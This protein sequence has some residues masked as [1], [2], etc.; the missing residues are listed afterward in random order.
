VKHDAFFNNVKPNLDSSDDQESSRV[1]L[2]KAKFYFAGGCARLMFLFKTADVIE[3]LT[4]S[5]AAVRDIM[6]YIKGSLG[7]I[8]NAVINRL[9]SN[10]HMPG[11]ISLKARKICIVSEWAASE[12]C[13]PD[14]VKNL[15]ATARDELTPAMDGWLFEMWFFA[16]LR[17]SCVILCDDYGKWSSRV[18]IF[19]R[20]YI[21]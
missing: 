6:P 20:A 9:F 5:V 7:D 14:L 2:I 3:Y 15:D 1:D 8:S 12:L 21:Y 10:Y 18:G 16:L 13:G 11:S 4:D 17:H 19:Y